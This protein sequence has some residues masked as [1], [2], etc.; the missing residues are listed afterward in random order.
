MC[1]RFLCVFAPLRE[2]NQIIMLTI[3][4]LLD[5]LN[6]HFPWNRVEKWDTVGLHIGD[7]NADLS[8]VYV[9]YEVT[10][11]AI[12][13]ATAGGAG[14]IVAYHP[15][16]FRPLASLDFSDPTARL[17]AR[18]VREKMALICVH[19]AL[20]GAPP[21]HALG[22]ALAAQLG[23]R[24]VRVGAASGA[25]KL[26]RIATYVPSE[27]LDAVRDAMWSAGAGKIGVLYDQASFASAG[28][29][30]FRPLEGANPAI[31]AIGHREQVGE[32]QLEVIAPETNWPTI[33]AALR[34]A[35]PYEEVAYN[36]TALLNDDQSGSYG[37]LRIG[38]VAPQSLDSW[39]ETVREKLNPPS[40]RVVAPD[41][42]GEVEVVACSPGSGA[43]FIGKLARGTT[44]VCA[45]IKHHDAL[46]AR[47]RGVALIDVTHAATE[48]EA[49]PLMAGALENIGGLKVI[50]ELKSR[51]PFGD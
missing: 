36:V 32:L 39:I 40:I 50:R 11:A 44:F 21:P 2:I 13:A 29:G 47:A 1:L 33:V 19:S 26:V 35:H 5:E 22:D 3:Q 28:H 15:L 48:T 9:C 16:L 24:E 27:N 37:P 6:R 17:A 4:T 8:A 41:N 10:D 43:S 34:A 14:A 38:Q 7:K 46:Q 20:D 45:D 30:T 31:G 25:P 49:V 18:I 12:D 23:L 42:F 51:N